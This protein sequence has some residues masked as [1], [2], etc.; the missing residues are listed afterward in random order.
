M[1]KDT[2]IRRL[3]RSKMFP[4]LIVLVAVIVMFTSIKSTYITSIDNLRGI[5]NAMSLTGTIAVGVGCLL[6]SGGMDLSVGAVG[7]FA[8]VIAALMIRSGMPWGIAMLISVVTG[9]AVGAFNAFLIN[10]L[11]FMG[12]IATIG[13]S[14]MLQ[15][16]ANV[17]TGGQNI[18]VSNESFFRLGST[19]L[20]RLF[21]LPFIIAFALM[22]I[23]GLILSRTRFGRIMY[24][25]GGNR[26]AAQMVG[27]KPKKIRTI[28][29][30]NC[31][32]L[33]ALGGV[34][35]AARMR[36]G[37]P[38]AVIGQE[39]DAIT[40]A[41]LG[42]ISFMGGGGS[43]GGCLVGLALLTCFTNGLTFVGLKSY[44]TVVAQGA[45]LIVAL[46][47]DYLNQRSLNRRLKEV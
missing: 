46:V 23:Y 41:V 7:C 1:E 26:M 12:F 9:A 6:I 16:L 25:C 47:V 37:S 35:L 20:I 14:S 44:W 38:A 4:L 32:A 43:M 24:M 2:F 18:S 21:S 3:T 34:V 29:H 11:N 40:A 39:F 19:T 17:I 5:F 45:V 28:L 15:G 13:V 36:S 42:G 31:S 27:L 33:A 10:G 22:V 8:G 30:I